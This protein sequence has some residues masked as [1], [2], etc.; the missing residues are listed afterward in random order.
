M[1]IFAS[2][3]EGL[4][5][6]LAKEI[7]VLGGKDIKIKK[8]FV[9][10]K[11]NY[12]TLYKIHFYSRIAFRFYRE[13]ARFRCSN[14]ED[15]YQ[16][17]KSSFDWSKWLP[18]NKSFCVHVTGKNSSLNHSHFNALQVKNSIVDL[19]N[20]LFGQRSNISFNQP[21]LVIH[22][23]I[24]SKEGILSLQTTDESLHK[25]GYR[26]SIGN[27]PLKEN[28]AAGLIQITNWKGDKP[29]I[30]LMCGSGTLLIEAASQFLKKPVPHKNNYLFEN[31]L[32]FDEDLFKEV[33]SK[34]K[35]SPSEIS[36]LPKIIGCEIDRDVSSQA[37]DNINLARLAKLIEIHNIDFSDLKV[38]DN[39]GIILCNPPYGKKLGKDKNE[40][41]DLYAKIGNCL[42]EKFSGWEFWL[43]SGNPE[44]TQ[45]LRMKASLKI[46]I[47][48]G[49]ID[50][51]WIKYEIR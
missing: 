6:Q 28:L 25:R 16:G 18:P 45:Y 19:Q 11:S 9:S 39:R 23:H 27:A 40:L 3:P 43:L 32:D 13:V 14:K 2:S 21:Y 34:T 41:I 51:R 50:C 1:N 15:L 17:V 20:A 47:S 7:I 24:N 35:K 44:L 49:G 30:D 33:K 4:E 10:F 26:P 22:L 37:K 12:E 46:P 42:K 31:W 36:K 29:L 8:R 48:N 5:H 38:P